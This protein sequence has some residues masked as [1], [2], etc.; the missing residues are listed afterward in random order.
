MVATAPDPSL[1]CDGSGKAD[2]GPIPPAGCRLAVFDLD[3]TLYRQRPLRKRMALSLAGSVITKRTVSHVRTISLYR[4]LREQMAGET[5]PDFEARLLTAVARQ[6]GLTEAAVSDVVADWIDERPLP[7]LR[8]CVTPGAHALFDALR[9]AGIIIGV[10]SDYPVARKLDALG[11]RADLMACASDEGID[12]LKPDPAGLLW[13]LAEAGVAPDQAWMI[14]DR[15]ERD[16]E[17]AQRAGV[18]FLLRA[19]Q[20]PRGI[21]HVPD[22]E[23]LARRISSASIAA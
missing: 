10:W 4:S 16:G 21:A 18:S 14:G 23:G 5:G 6:S 15:V 1:R 9:H 3:G 13:M 12:A 7:F 20:A 22:F 17:A 8:R 19:S 11:L 2:D